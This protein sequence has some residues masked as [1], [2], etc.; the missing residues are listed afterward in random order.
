MFSS[1]DDVV[2]LNHVGECPSWRV[3]FENGML[4]VSQ[5]QAN[6]ETRKKNSFTC[7]KLALSLNFCV[8]L[9]KLFNLFVLPVSSLEKLE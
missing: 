9:D 5:H 4:I 3:S 1:L 7:Q 8:F 2:G 6:C